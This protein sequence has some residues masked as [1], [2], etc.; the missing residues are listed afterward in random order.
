MLLKAKA[1]ES[2]VAQKLIAT[3]AELD[4]IAAG[5]RDGP[6]LRGWR[7]KVFGTDALRLC[8]GEIALSAKGSRVRIVEL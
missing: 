2:R 8:G 1:D 6:A 5:E 4:E 3:A 7:R